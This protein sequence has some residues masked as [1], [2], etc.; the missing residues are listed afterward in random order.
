MR[1][2][3]AHT[4]GVTEI[5]A[6]ATRL[7]S[8]TMNVADT[9]SCRQPTRSAPHH[10]RHG[11]VQTA[12][13]RQ[14]R[15]TPRNPIRTTHSAEGA[16]GVGLHHR[17]ALRRCAT[18]PE[19]EWSDIAA[20]RVGNAFWGRCAVGQR[21]NCRKIVLVSIKVATFTPHSQY[22]RSADAHRYALKF[23]G[24]LA[25]ARAGSA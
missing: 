12:D 24:L 23:T 22:L 20:R 18:S 7:A 2:R 4:N 5:S 19:A 9:A 13:S 16:W 14:R 25:E 3:C 17:Y 8:R 6:S 21:N 15:V 11:I 1:P 10:R